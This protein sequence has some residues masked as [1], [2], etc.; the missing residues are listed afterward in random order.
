MGID[1]RKIDRVL[2]DTPAA[3][4]VTWGRWG[5]TAAGVAAAAAL[6]ASPAMAGT[7]PDGTGNVQGNVIVGSAITLSLDATVFTITDQAGVASDSNTIHATVVSNDSAGYSVQ[8]VGPASFAGPGANSLATNVLLTTQH[9]AGKDADGSDTFGG[10]ATLP[11]PT[12]AALVVA[13]QTGVSGSG[14]DKYMEGWELPASAPT[15]ASGTY[16]GAV[17]FSVWGV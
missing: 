3:R 9:P 1:M 14:G 16:S 17:T 11:T 12:Q 15:L 6:V 5:L 10:W 8:E 7:T 2:N 13:S 4:R